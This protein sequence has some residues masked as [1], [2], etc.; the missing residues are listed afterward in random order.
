MNASEAEVVARVHEALETED[1]DILIDLRHQNTNQSDK[2]EVFWTC[3]LTFLNENT[4][5]HERRHDQATYM[6]KAISVR[7]LVEQ[8][9]MKCPEGTPIP[10]EQWVCL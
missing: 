5:V 2:Y 3:A 6:A 4:A 7:D 8:V 9:R 1:L 10:S